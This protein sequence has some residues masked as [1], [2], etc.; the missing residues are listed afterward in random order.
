M[1]RFVKY[2]NCAGK[3]RQVGRVAALGRP[4]VRIDRGQF[5]APPLGAAP[6]PLWGNPQSSPN[7]RRPGA[8]PISDA[9]VTLYYVDNQ[10]QQSYLLTRALPR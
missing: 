5:A 3:G 6:P 8:A 1:E 10:V 2:R 4:D 7:R 9:L